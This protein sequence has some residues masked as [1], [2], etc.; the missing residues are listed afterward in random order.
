MGIFASKIISWITF[1]RLAVFV[2]LVVGI[3][4]IAPQ[5][6]F[7]FSPSYKG[8]QMLGT[9]GENFYVARIHEIYEGHF[10]LGN[11]FLP[12]KDKP[13]M[14]TP[15]GEILVGGLG[16]VLSFSAVGVAVFSK[17]LFP[18]FLFLLF[19]SFVY[20]IFLSASNRSEVSVLGN[21]EAS[22]CIAIVSASL[23]LLGENLLSSVRDVAGLAAFTTPARDFLLYTRPI[24]PEVSSLFLFSALYLLWKVIGREEAG[25]RLLLFG[26][27]LGVI[28]GFS[29]YV[30]IYPWS[31]LF[32]AIFLSL[33]YASFK[34]RFCVSAL[35][36]A[37]GVHI[38]VTA[39][40]WLNFFWARMYPEY[41][42]AAMR[43]GLVPDHTPVWG[44]LL[45][46]STVTVFLL[47]PKQYARAKWFFAIA[48]L[49]LWIVTNQQVITGVKLQVG[50]YHWYIVKPIAS[51][52]LSF[53]FIFF[54]EHIIKRRYLTIFAASI[55]VIVF[56]YNAALIQLFSYRTYYAQTVEDQRYAA[57]ISYLERQYQSPQTVWSDAR[58][59]SFVPMYTIHNVPNSEYIF[60]SLNSK[61]YLTRR[62]FLEY[63]LRG[64]RPETLGAVLRNEEEYVSSRVFGIYYHERMLPEEVFASLETQYPEFYRLP[65]RAVFRYFD[66]NL[67]VW[68]K[69]SDG[70]NPYEQISELEKVIEIGDDFVIYRPMS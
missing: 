30:Y 24:H 46:F 6:F 12:D 25:G 33:A 34:K 27:C 41:S 53:I 65:Y 42:D 31:F 50:H 21:G 8:V 5:I 7:S 58:I 15:F 45:V 10:S 40:Y 62:L 18:F 69:Q 57:L 56:I 9:D 54:F 39:P 63:R 22:K 70:V 35:L 36:V 11:V 59:A 3:I 32:V 51:I 2:A 49:S 61:G 37:I 19:Y 47:W 44:L 17:M 16:N 20:E 48:V 26:V 55:L 66:I 28:S 38:A 1:H 29:I 14:L 4:S 67:I 64:V 68:D 43:V 13:Y 23:F 52:L 60:H